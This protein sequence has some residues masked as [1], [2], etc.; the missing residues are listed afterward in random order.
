MDYRVCTPNLAMFARS[1]SSSAQPLLLSAV[2]WFE[3]QSEAVA[4]FSCDVF[5]Y[6]DAASHWAGGVCLS[7][8]GAVQHRGV[9]SKRVSL[10][11]VRLA[12]PHHIERAT[13]VRVMRN[14]LFTADKAWKR[15]DLSGSQRV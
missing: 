8:R 4:F 2:V 7:G 10:F 6:M 3:T 13:V 15:T 14:G 5:R 11:V 12:K 1:C 9:C